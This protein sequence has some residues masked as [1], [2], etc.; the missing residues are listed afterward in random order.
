MPVT[1]RGLISLL[2][3]CLADLRQVSVAKTRLNTGKHDWEGDHQ[4]VDFLSTEPAT[5]AE[6]VEA[7]V[8]RCTSS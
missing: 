4:A 5:A 8:L 7:L 3:D 1:V 2:Q 6:I